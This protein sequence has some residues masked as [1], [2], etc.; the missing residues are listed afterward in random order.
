[1]PPLPEQTLGFAVALGAGLLIGLDRERRKGQGAD[2]QPAGIRSFTIASLAG[3]LAQALG[4]PLLVALGGAGVLALVI[5][6]YARS[7]SDDPGLTT[8]LALFVTYLVGVLSMQQPALGAGVGAVVAALLAW[9]EVLHRFATGWLSQGELHDAVLLAA[10]V[11]VVL[12]L[13]PSEPVPWLGDLV[14]RRLVG[15]AVLILAVQAAGHVAARVAGAR[16]G[17]AL[18]GLFS[19][20]VS[21]TATVAANGARARRE[22]GRAAGYEA[23]AM[24]STAATWL[25]ALLLLAL[26][27]PALAAALAP[28]AL[29]GTA[30]AAAT[31]VWRARR[32]GRASGGGASPGAEAAHA[33]VASGAGHAG[34]AERP[35]DAG[36]QGGHRGPLR[37]QEAALL[38]ALL[39][40]VA[41]VISWAQRWLGD[42]GVLAGAAA[43]ALAD[44]H[45]SV[46]TLANL[47][48]DGRLPLA[49][50]VLGVLLAVTTNALSRAGVA[51]AAGG[52][53]YGTRVGLSLAASTAAAWAA[54]AATAAVG[55]LAAPGALS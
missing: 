5:V 3:A 6:A 1:V 36:R 10:F 40:A 17:L 27:A 13:T 44:A 28:A 29:A 25:Q 52:G 31:G 49:P 51:V 41:L 48:A 11:L 23:G 54:W 34:P 4:A 9:R 53:G 15:I 20:F 14:P 38:A 18:A 24:L 8:E 47:H 46:A 45:A 30:V 12:P 22:P 32:A 7:R 55:A 35:G 21:S 43:G 50:A 19:G 26:L 42:A 37:L 2:R 16:A 39:V 33:D